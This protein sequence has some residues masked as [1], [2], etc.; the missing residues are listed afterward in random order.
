MSLNPIDAG[1]AEVDIAAVIAEELASLAA[2]ARTLAAQLSPGDV[3][4]AVVLPSNGLTDLLDIGGLR[5]AAQLPPTVVPGQT[6]AVMVTGF[7]GDR[8][9]LQ[10]VP[11][12][13][14]PLAQTPTRRP[15]M[16]GSSFGSDP[17]PA[18]R[19]D[20]R[21]AA[22]SDP[23]ETVAGSAAA[24]SRTSPS[25]QRLPAALP[26]APPILK[27]IEARLAAAHAIVM[28]T[29]PPKAG[30]VRPP[31]AVTTG[32][33]PPRSPVVP[34]TARGPLIEPAARS[35]EA[36]PLVRT[37][38]MPPAPLGAAPAARAPI[39]PLPAPGVPLGT[40]WARK[41]GGSVAKPLEPPIVPH[42]AAATPAPR[43][44]AAF[45]DPAALLRALRLPVT[46]TNLAAARMA[47][48]T[49]EK[50][51]NALAALERALSK[52]G[53]PVLNTL[54]T[55]VSFVA[56]LDPRSPVLAT[57]IAA[58]ADHVVTGP[59]A[60]I[61]Q[62]AAEGKSPLG[63]AQPPL[64]AR[65]AVLRA[66]LDFDLKT[67]LL[68]LAVQR[69]SAGAPTLA[70]ADLDRAVAGALTAITVLQL[71]AATA[72]SSQ[73]AEFAFSLP[74]ALPDGFAQAHVRIDRDAPQ[75]RGKPLDGDDFHIA[76]ILE[77]RHLGTVAIE[78]T[79]VGRAVTLS[80]KTEAVPAQRVFAN[81]MSRLSRRL[82]SLHYTIAKTDS[83][84][85]PLAA[86]GAAARAPAALPEP[87]PAAGS[88]HRVDIGA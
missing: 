68:A 69:G 76:F 21:D 65:S 45:T 84:V 79:T 34:S 43:G 44:P 74:I 77:T 25:P 38:I 30:P 9:N 41:P 2:D 58:F 17:L 19:T 59:E 64:D 53:D 70:D 49:P 67:Q 23:R 28:P 42:A 55:L 86:V 62:L 50:L 32:A 11:L 82:E 60:K 71:N 16:Q 87:E 31:A 85:A 83:V 73:P 1:N 88:A 18:T 75:A 27:T 78:L 29:A 63:G 57:Q 3:V 81:A 24:P 54:R 48:E 37:P 8:I 10:I 14:A 72:L 51:P 35:F 13:Q 7:E 66:G 56:R 46:A 47:L 15:V 61:A 5:V 40:P 12:P 4:N 39:G 20:S 52:S 26:A 80:V 36:P 6:I 22:G 33:T